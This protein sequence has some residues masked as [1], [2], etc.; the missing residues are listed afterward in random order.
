M[1]FPP[2]ISI[3]RRRVEELNKN[4]FDRARDIL[5][6]AHVGR[7]DQ[8]EEFRIIQESWTTAAARALAI[9]P[10]DVRVRL[11]LL[12]LERCREASVPWPSKVLFDFATLDIYNEYHLQQRM[13][14]QMQQLRDRLKPHILAYQ[15]SEARDI[16]TRIDKDISDQHTNWHMQKRS[17]YRPTSILEWIPVV[18][19]RI[20]ARLD[21]EYESI[22][23]P[24]TPQPPG[25]EVTTARDYYQR[26]PKHAMCKFT[27]CSIFNEFP[28]LMEI[29][30]QPPM[31]TRPSLLEIYSRETIVVQ[32]TV[33]YAIDTISLKL[34]IDKDLILMNE[35]LQIINDQPSLNRYCF[36]DSIDGNILY[37]IPKHPKTY[38][39]IISNEPW[40]VFNSK[41]YL[42][43]KRDKINR[44]EKHRYYLRSAIGN[45]IKVTLI[46]NETTLDVG[47]YVNNND[48][49]KVDLFSIPTGYGRR[50]IPYHSNGYLRRCEARQFRGEPQLIPSDLDL[51]QVIIK[52]ASDLSGIPESQLVVSEDNVRLYSEFQL[53]NRNSINKYEKLLIIRVEEPPAY[54]QWIAQPQRLGGRSRR[55]TMKIAN[56]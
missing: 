53:I 4:S 56:K 21:N 52:N 55:R 30:I 3:D 26:P 27:V 14:T 11:Q 10:Q 33:E 16:Q 49:R 40:C 54:M 31:P 39:L 41:E 5:D 45:R 34:G 48:D 29:D 43:Y 12:A 38:H 37:I 8:E 13:P 25:P 9:I 50:T 44:D 35:N 20:T 24:F 42:A 19:S 23:S 17:E 36:S 6:R 46:F 18:G 32:R 2:T 28:S 7:K 1:Q 22:P 47:T 51:I 15:E